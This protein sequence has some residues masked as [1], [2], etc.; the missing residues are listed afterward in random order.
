MVVHCRRCRNCFNM[1]CFLY[2]YTHKKKKL[3]WIYYSTFSDT[4]VHT[5]LLIKWALFLFTEKK[6]MLLE[7]T[8][9][10]SDSPYQL[11]CFYA[12]E[13]IQCFLKKYLSHFKNRCRRPL[14]NQMSLVRFEEWLWGTRYVC[15]KNWKGIA[16]V[17]LSRILWWWFSRHS[18]YI[19]CSYR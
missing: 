3:G 4:S 15:S 10:S 14:R 18:V 11:I 12:K 13:A 5:W 8:F 9:P 19:T 17:F 7:A 16:S 6:M 2:R 1:L